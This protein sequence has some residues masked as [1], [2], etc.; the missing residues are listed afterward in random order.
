MPE[1]NAAE[2]FF[3]ALDESLAGGHFVKLTLARY[4]GA[5]SGLKNVYVRPAELKGGKRL[6]FLYRH[7]TRDLVRNHTYE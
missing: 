7:Q 2:Q 6:S 1:V 3:A 5:E 4:R